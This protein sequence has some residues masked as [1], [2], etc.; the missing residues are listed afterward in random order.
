KGR[1]GPA[2]VHVWG[3]VR[4]VENPFLAPADLH[5]EGFGVE[6]AVVDLGDGAAGA[7]NVDLDSGDLRECVVSHD[8]QHVWVF[9]PV[10]SPVLRVWQDVV[11]QPW[12]IFN[13]DLVRVPPW[14]VRA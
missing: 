6:L 9:Q 11:R 7:T 4:A 13:R 2:L 12:K 1:R 10:R 5:D 14:L 3:L 8:T